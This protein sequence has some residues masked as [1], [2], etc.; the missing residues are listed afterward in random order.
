MA[1]LKVSKVLSSLPGTL[2]ANMIYLVR[3]GTG[4]D[5][6]VVDSTGTIAYKTNRQLGSPVTT[7]TGDP[8]TNVDLSLGDF[9]VLPLVNNVTLTLSNAPDS[10]TGR[11]IV[12]LVG[13]PLTGGKTLTLPSSFKSLGNSDTAIQSGASALTLIAAVSVGT[14]NWYYSMAKVNS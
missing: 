6:Y 11:S 1:T 12:I 4:L 13:Q 2:V 3:V 5:I 14:T 10:S 7:L 9:F 8:T